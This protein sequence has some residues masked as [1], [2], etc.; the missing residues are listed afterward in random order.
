MLA[1]SKRKHDSE[2]SAGKARKRTNRHSQNWRKQ[3]QQKKATLLLHEAKQ[4]ER[5]KAQKK[6]RNNKNKKPVLSA[7]SA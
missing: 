6:N 2:I 4:V 1:K 7:N 3:Q 5:Q